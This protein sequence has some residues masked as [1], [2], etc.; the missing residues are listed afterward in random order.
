MQKRLLASSLLLNAL[1]ITSP[2]YAAK[3]DGYAFALYTQS[4][5]SRL[6]ARTCSNAIPGYRPRFD[7]AYR[8][9]SGKNVQAIATGE[10]IYHDAVNRL[11]RNYFVSH[12][13]AKKPVNPDAFA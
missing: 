11:V 7:S 13:G 4:L 5:T 1:F 6:A 2:V 3:A 8:A 10:Q 9:W 12:V